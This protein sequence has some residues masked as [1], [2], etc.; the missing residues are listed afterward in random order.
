MDVPSRSIRWSAVNSCKGEKSVT[1][2]SSR[3]RY[4]RFFKFV[5]EEISVAFVF[6]M[7]SLRRFFRFVRGERSEIGTF[8]GSRDCKV[9]KSSKGVKSETSVN[10]RSI[11]SSYSNFCKAKI[12]AISISEKSSWMTRLSRS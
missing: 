11:S 9:V 10:S 2:V 1:A 6:S 12:S 8:R 7:V 4:S 3:S 5:R